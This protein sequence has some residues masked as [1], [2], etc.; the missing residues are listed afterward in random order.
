IVHGNGGNDKLFGEDGNDTLY[1]DADSDHLYGGQGTDKL[2]GGA[3]NDFLYG[4]PGNDQL[5]G[6]TGEDELYGGAD[7]DRLDGG[8]GDD[9]YFLTNQWGHD[10]VAEAPTP[11]NGRNT[12]DFGLV[13]ETVT[14]ILSSGQLISGTNFA[15][16]S[17]AMPQSDLTGFK[18]STGRVTVHDALGFDAGQQ[19]FSFN[20]GM[21]VVTS[22]R[23]LLDVVDLGAAD[24]SQTLR[25]SINTGD[26]SGEQIFEVSV[27]QTTLANN[28]SI[29]RV[30]Q[31]I[32][33]AT[34]GVRGGVVAVNA[35]ENDTKIEIS[36]TEAANSVSILVL[37]SE[38]SFADSLTMGRYADGT[39]RLFYTEKIKVANADN[40][41]L[42]GNDWAG[43]IP[44]RPWDPDYF[45]AV[46]EWYRNR[47][48]RRAGDGEIELEIDTRA[49]TENGHKLVL[50][51]R[52]VTKGLEFDFE[53]TEEGIRL[54]VGRGEEL[55]FPLGIEIGLPLPP[56]RFASLVFTNVDENTVIY[57]GRGGNEINVAPGTEFKGTLIGSSGVKSPW[58]IMK[59]QNFVD[60]LTLGQLPS[61]FVE[62]YV[63]Y[64]EFKFLHPQYAALGGVSPLTAYNPAPIH[65]NAT[66]ENVSW[67]NDAPVVDGFRN[68][69]L[70]NV[71]DVAVGGGPSAAIGT[72]LFGGRDNYYNSLT[73]EFRQYAGPASVYNAAS[74]FLGD[75]TIAIGDANLEEDLL[76]WLFDQNS[77]RLYGYLSPG[78]PAL[79]AG[80]TGNDTYEFHGWWG[81][82]I[83]AEP[84]EVQNEVQSIDT[85]DFSGV[86]AELHAT[87]FRA[88]A[89][90]ASQAGEFLKSTGV[91]TQDPSE[92]FVG[93]S[94]N[95][96][97]V[98]TFDPTGISTDDLFKFLGE[99]ALFS[100]LNPA[101][102][103]GSAALSFFL[104]DGSGDGVERNVKD[105]GKEFL[106]SGQSFLSALSFDGGA[107]FANDIES[108]IG[109]SGGLTVH[110]R[111]D[112]GQ[113]PALAGR[114]VGGNIS[115]DYST[116]S[117]P[118]L[119]TDRTG[120]RV[121]AGSIDDF[122]ANVA[123]LI[124]SLATQGKFDPE[125]LDPEALRFF[126]ETL[127]ELS[128][129]FGMDLGDATLVGGARY[130]SIDFITKQLNKILDDNASSLLTWLLD[131]P[132]SNVGN[133]YGTR[134]DDQLYGN[135]R[136]NVIIGL[137]GADDVYGGEG[138]DI[139]SYGAIEGD[140]NHYSG[141]NITFNLESGK[142]WVSDTSGA[143]SDG[144]TG[145][146]EP[147]DDAVVTTFSEIEVV[148]GGD[149]NDLFI[150]S[151]ES[152][153]YIF[154][155]DWGQDIIRDPGDDNVLNFLNVEEELQYNVYDNNDESWTVVQTIDGTHKLIAY[156]KFELKSDAEKTENL[157]PPSDLTA[158]DEV[159][160]LLGGEVSDQSL[161]EEGLE[162][163]AEW[164][165][166]AGDAIG[167]S[168][169]RVGNLPW[170]NF[171]VSDLLG[172]LGID[173]LAQTVSDKV[174]SQILDV[175]TSAFAQG[176]ITTQE[177]IDA[178]E[179]ID[180]TFSSNLRE[181]AATVEVARLSLDIGDLSKEFK[182][183][184]GD[185]SFNFFDLTVTESTPLSL[186]LEFDLDFVFGLDGD[187][188]FYVKDT[189]ALMR[190]V[191]DHVDPI[192]LSVALGPL[193]MGVQDGTLKFDVGF[194]LGNED[195]LFI[196]DMQKDSVGSL[197]GSPSLAEDAN[198]VIFLPLQ[199]QGALAGLQD[200][201]TF[202]QGHYVGDPTHTNVSLEQF[203]AAFAGSLFSANLGG[204]LDFQQV[205][206][207][208]VL[209]GLI[210]A[211]DELVG[212]DSL[213]YKQLP[214]INKSL[215]EVLGKES[216]NIMT[217]IRNALESVRSGLGHI[218]DFEI[219]VNYPLN[220]ALDLGLDFGGESALELKSAL[221]RLHVV[222]A[223][224]D[225]LS[226]DGDLELAL[227][228][229]PDRV[230]AFNALR[231][232]RDVMIAA[233]LLLAI[234][235]SLSGASSDADVAIALANQSD[236]DGYLQ[237]TTDQAQ[238]KSDPQ[239]VSSVAT[240]NSYGFNR[241]VALADIEDQL[242]NIPIQQAKDSRD[243][244]L[245]GTTA[246]GQVV[247]QN[248]KALV[249]M[250]GVAIPP[251]DSATLPALSEILSN[252]APGDTDAAT[253][254]YHLLAASFLLADAGLNG[255]STNSEIEA[256][257]AF[258]G[259][260][261][262]IAAAVAARDLLGDPIFSATQSL[263]Q[264]QNVL[265]S[266]GLDVSN[267]AAITDDV[268][269]VAFAND[270][271]VSEVTLALQ[272]VQTADAEIIAI[273]DKFDALGLN[274]N[275]SPGT[276][277]QAIAD[278]DLYTDAISS[279]NYL[280][281][282]ATTP[283]DATELMSSYGLDSSLAASTDDALLASAF[284]QE[285][286]ELVVQLPDLQRSR[287][288]LTTYDTNRMIAL[289]YGDSQLFVGFNFD[290]SGQT[291]FD[292]HILETFL[293]DHVGLP[294]SVTFDIAEPTAV[295]LDG[296]MKVDILVGVD[297]SDLIDLSFDD[298]YVQ[299]ND[300]EFSAGIDAQD[301]SMDLGFG[302]LL[303]KVNDGALHLA[304]G[305][306]VTVASGDLISLEDLSD[307]GF[308]ALG[309]TPTFST[310]S[311]TLPLE[312]DVDG[313]EAAD[314]LITF[315]TDDLFGDIEN[316]I[317]KLPS[318]NDIANLSVADVING[319]RNAVDF[320]DNLA[321]SN[322]STVAEIPLVN[323]YLDTVLNDIRAALNF[324]EELE[325]AQT[326]Q[327]THNAASGQ[328]ELRFEGQADSFFIDATDTA[329]SL[330]QT[331]AGLMFVTENS[332]I[333][334][335]T[336]DGSGSPSS[337][338]V[339]RFKGGLQS[340][341]VPALTLLS[342]AMLQA[343]G[344]TLADVELITPDSSNIAR[345]LATAQRF[346]QNALGVDDTI[347]QYVYTNA[348]SGELTLN[349]AGD[350]EKFTIAWNA[351]SQDVVNALEGLSSINRGDVSVSGAGSS[352]DPWIIAYAGALA[353]E[354]L[355]NLVVD[356]SSLLDND[357][358]EAMISIVGKPAEH[359][360][361]RM[362]GS[363]VLLDI[364]RSFQ[365]GGEEDFHFSLDRVLSLLPDGS[366]K[367]ALS[368]LSNL[369]DVN[370]QGG[371]DIEMDGRIDLTI[372]F[373]P[374][375][376]VK[377]AVFLTDDSTV[378]VN[379]YI[380]AEDLSFDVDLDVD[381]A[382]ND[383]DKL[384]PN[385]TLTDALKNAGV[386]KGSGIDKV[387]IHILG[388]SVQLNSGRDQ[389]GDGQLDP[390]RFH[391]SFEADDDPDP[392][393]DGS[394]DGRYSLFVDEETRRVLSDASHLSSSGTL[395]VDL[396]IFLPTESSPMGGSAEDRNGDGVGDNVLQ[397]SIADLNQVGTVG[398]A[399]AMQVI[400]PHFHNSIGLFALLNN[401]DLITV[402]AG[403]EGA[404]DGN[405]FH[406]GIL[407]TLQDVLQGEIF[408]IG[409]PFIGDRLKQEADFIGKFRDEIR[410]A[411]EGLNGDGNGNGSAV[412]LIETALFDVFHHDLGILTDANGDGTVDEKD[413]L[414]TGDAE[415]VQ[416]NVDIGGNIFRDAIPIDFGLA[417]PGLG[418][419]FPDDEIMLS[420]DYGFQFGFG[421]SIHDGFYFDASA[422]DE[423]FLTV[424][425]ELQNENPEDPFSATAR[426]GIL[427]LN[428]VDNGII[429]P[430]G[431]PSGSAAVA[432]GG[433]G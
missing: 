1:G 257:P 310:M 328:A 378:T 255:D 323:D 254:S 214:L 145:N 324:A 170:V 24:L 358:A 315:Q 305:L 361:L 242:R 253:F 194:G 40:H 370:A 150:G 72:H 396:P 67:G 248:G 129:E 188:Q 365:F 140:E 287:D 144:A 418:L 304:A 136:D 281:N 326:Q 130:L 413:V 146:E 302:P 167:A 384:F 92:L 349:F 138:R 50:D 395:Q 392:Q 53:E 306:Q 235:A 339:I 131:A 95:F 375:Q 79:M 114:L 322:A 393:L 204:M 60:P 207:D 239:F 336:V 61:L 251:T 5:F 90:L 132:V 245:Q 159:P 42:F 314:K 48:S 45:T 30:M 36:V 94:T 232:A 211:F 368:G 399:G 83:V 184:L 76:D 156:G 338:F 143:R 380:D 84:F 267:P 256:S 208:Q 171:G 416:F 275:S 64:T 412:T 57:T 11:A 259:D 301:L 10:T 226:S 403:R 154:N 69:T 19:S 309:I 4:G 185:D 236:P 123:E 284:V 422:A 88:T 119:G 3:N 206:L 292:L 139:F 75:N 223:G 362:Q 317:S 107:V 101:G 277:A 142:A 410:S 372:G 241:S 49:A 329:E 360:D 168:F 78:T 28:P 421:L 26:G 303:T 89:A 191:V 299:V 179:Q 300:L 263:L 218:Q 134:F 108:I 285:I 192:E 86:D 238:L 258:S 388:G 52:Q 85:L 282:A 243:L 387:G 261:A 383:F 350:V 128:P 411:L 166:H 294:Q 195:K 333:T 237:L 169:D 51:F 153:E 74:R 110:F 46:S 189:A 105:I 147:D 117:T 68:G 80:L 225:G 39:S 356:A 400:T 174:Q 16:D 404:P 116:I 289:S 34:A 175:I 233:N 417:I 343:D 6:D 347:V 63:D 288:T 312:F 17:L 234:D 244:L 354:D 135:T 187:D 124:F 249:D 279:R 217:D 250:G 221:D 359:I 246:E 82:G 190:L 415:Y 398:T 290:L 318:I 118:N 430:S 103:L 125:T 165:A 158:T 276:V 91:F 141:G 389:D 106:S 12:V 18:P 186:S 273:A 157:K 96:V 320:I 425:A 222:S 55:E 109:G 73:D 181:F 278:P 386:L 262:Q 29:E 37:P 307:A 367:D 423:V 308:S 352:S 345:D 202:I 172:S 14:H 252:V 227:A 414:V 424:T 364:G 270:D 104:P 357:G 391:F 402:I 70:I 151:E 369:L 419:S 346:L 280:W 15:E 193:A 311:A 228:N 298:M 137:G 164:V 120:I 163:F 47:K 113:V 100:A 406:D 27:N 199:L 44:P 54:E 351:T 58:A 215:V 401:L 220:S 180:A 160:G 198:F 420:V 81:L 87:V 56:L 148:G 98:T 212:Q 348:A 127:E 337:P 428:V 321:I 405:P 2:Y 216:G 173:H 341:D 210:A 155:S 8:S 33:N 201:P 77:E 293:K 133:I 266:Q 62:N 59:P 200:E 397:V 230:D 22:T 265:Q 342:N 432:P 35:V 330:Q 196:S 205:S 93:A 260:A 355:P 427:E 286:P 377:D 382:L 177:V 43:K 182:L 176:D 313:I 126:Y 296:E 366:V 426:L 373:D 65:F 429:D 332:A 115:L 41:F 112:D 219:D 340:L 13:T 197:L 38:A 209:D 66:N 231:D 71:F 7:A 99:T 162:V 224:L 371:I 407:G 272:Y 331:I 385:N 409:L 229:L 178:S 327:I 433:G 213:A 344:V 21:V 335:V 379:L 25:L 32:R 334:E 122:D 374:T 408:G 269:E 203:F 390:A 183:D 274:A 240:L 23:P 381:Q 9:Q 247:A 295:T 264:A 363:A 325:A 102:D 353:G 152:Q 20:G 394:G 297:L 149:G 161:I 319:I 291:T 268:I 121:D 97:I 111:D 283:T 271:A 376:K 431:N 31:L 316:L